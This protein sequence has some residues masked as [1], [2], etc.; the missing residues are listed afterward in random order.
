MFFSHK[1]MVIYLSGMHCSNCLDRI[2]KSLSEEDHI[3]KVK[4]NIER[5][6]VVIIYRD[7]VDVERLKEIIEKL[8]YLVTGIKNID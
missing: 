1:K 6:E 7:T 4:G 5:Q 2:R 3:K 8:G